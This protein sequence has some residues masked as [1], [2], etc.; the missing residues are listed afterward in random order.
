MITYLVVAVA[1][2]L[3]DFV[4][5]EYTKAIAARSAYVASA[6]SSVLIGLSGFVAINY[7]EDHWALIPAAIGAFAGTFVSLRYLK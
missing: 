5:A 3:L 6:L 4:W 7:V 2:F 1:M